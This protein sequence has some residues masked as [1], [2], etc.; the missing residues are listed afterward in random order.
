MTTAAPA[1][2]TFPH[3]LPTA[4]WRVV[5]LEGYGWPRCRDRRLKQRTYAVAADAARMVTAIKKLPSHHI[6]IAVYTTGVEWN[7]VTEEVVALAATI[8]QERN[9]GY[10]DNDEG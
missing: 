2:R 9:D 4:L 7:P 6:L 10:I 8:E 3:R 5:W 1:A